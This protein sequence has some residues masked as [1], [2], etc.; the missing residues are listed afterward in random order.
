ME[1]LCVSC[2][3][4]YGCSVCVGEWTFGVTVCVG[5]W[6]FVGNVVLVNRYMEELCVLVIGHME[7]MW[8]W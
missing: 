4:T 3:W 6:T 7:V 2:D 5:E 1:V 8:C